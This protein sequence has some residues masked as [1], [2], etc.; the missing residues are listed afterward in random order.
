V[1]V[2]AAKIKKQYSAAIAKVEQ[3]ATPEDVLEASTAAGRLQDEFDQLSRALRASGTEKG[4]ALAAQKLTIDQDFSLISVLSRAKALKRSDL[5]EKQQ[6]S[7]RDMVKKLEDA[8]AR[9]TAAETKLNERIAMESL[10]KANKLRI[11]EDD[12]A[13]MKSLYDRAAELLTG[14]CHL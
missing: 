5:T 14:G 13:E 6:T 9:A 11:K 12:S 4:R 8:T 3:A 7:L 2:A 1:V 10:Q